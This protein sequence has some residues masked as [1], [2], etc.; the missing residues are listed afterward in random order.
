MK[1][2][3]WYFVYSDTL[4]F[5]DR[6]AAP[7]FAYISKPIEYPILTGFFIQ[8]A[9]MIGKTRAGY[10]L[11]SIAGLLAAAAIATY[12]L[13]K[14]LSDGQKNNLLRYW[15]FAPSLL[16]FLTYNW[17][18][19]PVLF[20]AI[21]FYFF[22]KNRYPTTS[23]FLA[24]GASAKLYPIFY[25]APLILKAKDWAE[26]IKIILVFGLTFAAVNLPFMIWNFSGWSYFFNLNSLRN[27]NPDSIWTI[28]RFLFRNLT[29]P[30]INFL[31]AVL[32]LALAIFVLWKFRQENF[33]KICFLLTLIFLLTNKV[34]TPQYLMWL[35][36]F[37]VLLPELKAKWFYALEFSNLAA[38]FSI[39][40]WFFLGRDPFYFYLASPFVIL[41]HLILIFIL[42]QLLRVWDSN[43]IRI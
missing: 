24:L 10:Y 21:A 41:R 7:G 38:F 39:L 42:F 18:I 33:I 29:I 36:P 16:I 2:V 40:P 9:G 27:S 26:R 19:L 5:F 32:F 23:A 1:S 43:R 3:P 28:A 14:I 30:E 25:I 31:S 35:L 4:G 34:F 15:I 20:T 13:Y 12:F 37:W 22:Q 8:L 11:A 6:V 17:D